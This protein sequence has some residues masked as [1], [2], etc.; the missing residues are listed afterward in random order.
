MKKIIAVLLTLVLLAV[1]FVGCGK[2]ETDSDGKK[3]GITWQTASG[4]S[5]FTGNTGTTSGDKNPASSQSS[6][7]NTT[8]NNS[9]SGGNNTNNSNQNNNNQN[10][11]SGGSSKPNIN[12]EVEYDD[13]II[14]DISGTGLTSHGVETITKTYNIVSSE[15]NLKDFKRYTY[16]KYE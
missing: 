14:T 8:N 9:S 7:G 1:S 4:D 12:I 5:T 2:K 3:G 16:I 15:Y 13:G 10:G 11:S 6:G